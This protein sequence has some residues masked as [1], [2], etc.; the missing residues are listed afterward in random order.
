VRRCLLVLLLPLCAL[1]QETKVPDELLTGLQS[2]DAAER[3]KAVKGLSKLGLDA[4]PH[5]ITALRDEEAQVSQSAAYALR[6][7]KADPAALV[8]ALSPHAK[9]KSAAVRAGVAGAMNRGGTDAAAVLVKLLD[10]DEAS[11]RRQS[12]QSLAVIASKTPEARKEALAGLQK[13]VKDD[14][15]PVRLDLARALPK[16]GEGSVKPLL[17]L[18]DD[19]EANVRAHALA[20]LERLTVRSKEALDVLKKK[21]KDDPEVIVR[22]SA[23]RTLSR[24]GKD[25]EPAVLEAL[26]DRKPEVQKAALNALPALKPD[27]KAAVPLIEDV[28]TKSDNASLRSAAT[29]A[30]KQFGDEGTKA[31]NRLLK[32]DDS[33][34]RMAC[35]RILVGD[36][37]LKKEHVGD[38][39]KA[40]SDKEADVRALAAYA[41]GELKADAKEALPALKKLLG[42]EDERVKKLAKQAA[43]KIEGK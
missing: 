23:I 43:E 9:D 8:K 16:C 25:A 33:A 35:L 18:A 2:K 10:D 4:V 17:T 37:A 14:S 34:V 11:V 29:H 27:A 39:I 38:L 19:A 12:V 20:G 7:L 41:L 36:K 30:L 32:R 13:R 22:Q 40:L 3:V 24:Y 31:I 21:A 15:T 6:I 1:A 26:T 28:A 5:L 42:D